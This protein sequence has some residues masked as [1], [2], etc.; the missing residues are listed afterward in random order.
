MVFR[1]KLQLAKCAIIY[2]FQT[3]V[4]NYQDVDLSFSYK[5]GLS[6]MDFAKTEK[7]LPYD[8]VEQ[9][10]T[11]MCKVVELQL[12]SPQIQEFIRSAEVCTL[13]AYVGKP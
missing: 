11:L 5:M 6:T 8:F 4:P 2:L 1:T 9:F 3:P 7:A 10:I 12:S 13:L